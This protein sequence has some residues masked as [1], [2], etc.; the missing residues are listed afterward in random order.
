MFF[1]FFFLMIRR[2]PRSTLFPYTTLFRSAGG[3]GGSATATG[4][5]SS[6]DLP[7]GGAQRRR[8]RRAFQVRR[9][10]PGGCSPRFRLARHDRRWLRVLAARSRLAA[11]RTRHD[12]LSR[13]AAARPLAVATRSGAGSG[14]PYARGD[15]GSAAGLTRSHRLDPHLTGAT[16]NLTVHRVTVGASAVGGRRGRSW[17]GSVSISPTLRSC[18]KFLASSATKPTPSSNSAPSTARLPMP[19]SSRACWVAVGCRTVSSRASISVP[20]TTPHRRLLEPE[21]PAGAQRG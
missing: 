17:A 6:H 11:S 5:R 14:R 15:P 4:R 7:R 21:P 3:A 20:P 16:L 13:A 10:P 2:P 19:V 12:H 18:S 1:F 8:H 9:L